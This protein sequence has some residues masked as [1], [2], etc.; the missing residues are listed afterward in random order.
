MINR[1][2]GT[3]L[4]KNTLGKSPRE[5]SCDLAQ[6]GGAFAIALNCLDITIE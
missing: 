5:K 6:A 2:D 3:C 1:S 4:G